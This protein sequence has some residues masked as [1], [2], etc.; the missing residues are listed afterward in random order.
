MEE[1]HYLID[2]V[3]LSRFSNN[4]KNKNAPKNFTVLVSDWSVLSVNFAGCEY[5]AEIAVNGVT[6]AD[7]PDIY[8]DES[9]I[10]PATSAEII[11]A[12]DTDKIILY[13][14]N[15]PIST[16]SGAYF[17]KRGVSI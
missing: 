14:K 2:L 17:I 16:L 6:L 4:M 13:A 10:A 15:I 1:E 12:T 11:A 3:L 7:Y 5:K 8:F 9:S